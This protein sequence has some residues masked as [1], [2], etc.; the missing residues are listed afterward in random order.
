MLLFLE[1][2]FKNLFKTV[3]IQVSLKIIQGSRLV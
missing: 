3:A 1:T 2:M